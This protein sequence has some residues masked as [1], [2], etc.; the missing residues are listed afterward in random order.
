MKKIS[1]LIADD[2]QLIRDTWSIIL[3]NDLRFEV[4]AVASSGEQAVELAKTT[5]PDIV[6]MDINMGNLNGFDA[7]KLLK[8]F[9]PGSKI[10]GVSMHAMPDYAKKMFKMGASGYV[11]KNSSREEFIHTILEVQ[12]GMT[13]ICDEVKEILTHREF[14]LTNDKPDFNSLSKREL[15]VIAFIKGGLS[16]REIGEKLS[17][18]LKTIEVHRY[19]ILKKLVVRNTASLVNLMNHHAY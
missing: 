2:H 11:T 5:C 18:S 3:N 6:L 16:S 8:S 13:C 17:L 9:S 4:V 14:E 1:I 15:D 7:T 10:I 19:N 12:Q